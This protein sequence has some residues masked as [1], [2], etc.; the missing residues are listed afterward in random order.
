[1]KGFK[2]A[3]LLLICLYSSTRLLAQTR[4]SAQQ[5]VLGTSEDS[6]NSGASKNKTVISGYGMATY[7]KDVVLKKS[8]MNLERAVLFIGH[9]FNRKISFFS[10]LE[11]ENGLVAGDGTS[12]GEI[13]MEQAFLKFN[14]NRRQYII[15]GLFTPRIGIINENH[16]PVNFNGVERP[17][18][19]QLII[20]TTW[21]ELGVGLYGTPSAIPITYSIAVVNGLNSAQMRHG[22]GLRSAMAEG[23]QASANNL[24]ITAAL[25]YPV[26]DFR[27]Q[28]SG[29][30]GGTVGL[31]PRGADSLNLQSG[32]FGTPIYLGEGDV[33]WSHEAFSGK[34]LGVIVSYPKASTINNAYASNV[35]KQMWGAYAEL[36]YDWLH[37]QN[38]SKQLISFVRVEKLN[39]NSKI[40]QNGIIDGTLDQMNTIVGFTYL[41]LPNI[42]IKADVRLLHTGKQNQELIINP[43]PNQLP[44]R[45]N[46]QFINLGIGYA[47]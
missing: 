20:P 8:M 24:A 25:Q 1:M 2:S 12:K 6:L 22:D 30:A 35:P 43:P 46:Q 19:E 37:N 28:I 15:A 14:L 17:M 18:V 26:N 34:A 39:V 45:Q 33:Q 23:S 27:F 42:A 13:S 21:R 41:P 7:Q 44:Y 38:V 29:Y 47:F 40:P 32:T 10:E 5:L 4:T 31:S 36:G 9:Q 3:V 16:L 11:V